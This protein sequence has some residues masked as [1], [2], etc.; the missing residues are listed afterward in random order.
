MEQ[1]EDHYKQETRDLLS[2]VKRLQDE[3]RKL[4]NSLVAANE[5]DSAFSEDGNLD[6][7]VKT[8][9]FGI[10]K[11]NFFVFSIKLIHNYLLETYFEIELVKKLEITIEKQRNEIKKLDQSVI[12]YK[13]ENEEVN[14]IFS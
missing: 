12:D 3:N 7:I 6:I 1:I 2:T 5:R 10:Y 11:W 14:T 13:A 9:Y 4:A 8:V